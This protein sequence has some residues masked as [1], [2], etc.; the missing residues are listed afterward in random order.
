VTSTAVNRVCK[1]Y[2]EAL[3]KGQPMSSRTSVPS[4]RE[5]DKGNLARLVRRHGGNQGVT[6]PDNSLSGLDS[7]VAQAR[8]SWEDGDPTLGDRISELYLQV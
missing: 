4:Q 8:Q 3:S 2:A 1:R 6:F 7:L 5:V